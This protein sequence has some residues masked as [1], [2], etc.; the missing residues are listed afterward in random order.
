M[1]VAQSKDTE[2]ISKVIDFGEKLNEE[3]QKVCNETLTS[4]L[5][6]TIER[7]SEIEYPLD[8]NIIGILKNLKNEIEKNSDNYSLFMEELNIP[9][10]WEQLINKAIKCLRFFDKREPFIESKE[11]TLKPLAYG[12]NDLRSYFNQYTEF[13]KLLYGGAPYYR[14]HIIHVFRVWLLGIKALLEKNHV[15]LSYININEDCSI[16]AYEKISIWT[17]ISL[18][19]DLGY[20][21]EK[22]QSILDHTKSMVKPFIIN[23][24]ISM[25][26]NFNGIQT[27]MNDFVVR[28]LSSKMDLGKKDE[29]KKKYVARLQPKFY[30]KFQKSLEHNQHGILSCLI[31]YKLL[32]YFLESDFSINEDYGFDDEEKRQFYIRREILR[33]IASHTCEDIYHLDVYSFA[34]LLVVADDAQEW[35][36]KSIKNLYTDEKTDYNFNSIIFSLIP[37][38]KKEDK[39]TEEKPAEEKPVSSIIVDEEYTVKP[40]DSNSI[41]EIIDSS[42]RFYKSKKKIF[43]DGQDTVNRNFSFEKKTR[44]LLS[45]G[46]KP[47]L[48]ILIC[49]PK[50]KGSSFMV[51]FTSNDFK[52]DKNKFN[53]ILEK[54]FLKDVYNKEELEREIIYTPNKE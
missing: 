46:N 33:S 44:I 48:T 54:V 5:G 9:D 35:G 17:V 45:D 21:L 37:P 41:K 52:E 2:L 8:S 31:L 19:H 40:D 26:L 12:V 11:E 18:T 24:N 3:L 29:E 34:F 22:A 7:K 32:L 39:S 49:I 25:D 36:R 16:T 6:K 27:N 4:F 38:P 10:L 14:D 47:T 23:P 15:Y 53:T 1:G 30:F 20:P 13:E 43:R 28:F 42:I 50:G 51:S